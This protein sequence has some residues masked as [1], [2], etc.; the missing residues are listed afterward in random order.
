MHLLDR[1]GCLL[2]RGETDKR[3]APWAARVSID[4]DVNV[5]DLADLGQQLA[6]LPIGDAEVEITYEYFV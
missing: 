1:L 6:E 3:E 2:L 4:W 5:H